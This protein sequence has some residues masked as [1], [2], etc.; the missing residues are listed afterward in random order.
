[1]FCVEQIDLS[2]HD[3]E[4]YLT[5]KSAHRKKMSHHLLFASTVNIFSILEELS[6]VE[7]RSSL[8]RMKSD[9]IALAKSFHSS[10]VITQNPLS[11]YF[12][13]R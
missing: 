8:P 1:M 3:R 5:P 11:R 4:S 6:D 2:G 13:W 9:T 10:G 12:K 7:V